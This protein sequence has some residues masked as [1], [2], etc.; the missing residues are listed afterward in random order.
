M[1]VLIAIL[2]WC[3]LLVMAWP[4]AL[5]LLVLLPFLWLL[6]IPFRIVGVA[7]RAVIAFLGAILF[8]PARLLGYRGGRP[9]L[10]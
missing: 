8:L 10:A 6:S 7:M 3:L 9:V 2:L 5:L 4:L 1:K